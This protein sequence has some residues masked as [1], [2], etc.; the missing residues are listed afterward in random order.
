M[1]QWLGGHLRMD[2]QKKKKK[3]KKKKK[4]QPSASLVIVW[5][6]FITKDQK[7]GQ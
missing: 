5:S 1:G 4:E 7:Y 2:N 3:K 6:F